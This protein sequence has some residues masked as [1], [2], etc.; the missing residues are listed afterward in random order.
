MY[1]APRQLLLVSYVLAHWCGV[2]V[3]IFSSR[4]HPYVNEKELLSQSCRVEAG[5]KSRITGLFGG[6]TWKTVCGGTIVGKQHILTAGHCALLTRTDRLRVTCPNEPPK[7]VIRTNI[8]P[9]YERTYIK[10]KTDILARDEWERWHGYKSLQLETT[11]QDLAV[12]EVGTEFTVEPVN[13]PDK[14]FGLNM[15]TD[16]G[17]NCVLSGYGPD[18]TG[19]TGNHRTVRTK[20]SDWKKDYKSNFS[21]LKFKR[22]DRLVASGDS[23]GGFVCLDSVGT[24][25]ILGVI[26]NGIASNRE[27]DSY[28]AL[29]SVTEHISWIENVVGQGGDFIPH[30]APIRMSR[31]L[32]PAQ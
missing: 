16:E 26:S 32:G 19:K 23:G 20:L 9:Y 3:A 30:V 31:H 18:D 13:L 6:I 14:D 24:P 29:T 27:N 22:K 1:Y 15:A 17:Q 7:E 5:Y 11:G 21:E 8:Q 25:H 12:L 2:S 4:S 10:H 28:S